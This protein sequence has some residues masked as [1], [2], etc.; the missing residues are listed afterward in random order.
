[1]ITW[2]DLFK[3]WAKEGLKFC[4]RVC[5]WGFLPITIAVIWAWG[6]AGAGISVG[7][8]VLLMAGVSKLC[9]KYPEF[10]PSIFNK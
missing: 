3:G 10:I 5:G 9:G 4:I 1:M 6:W 2:S 8:Y 7:L